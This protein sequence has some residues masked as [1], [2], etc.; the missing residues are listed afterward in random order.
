MACQSADALDGPKDGKMAA[1]MEGT[2]VVELVALMGLHMAAKKAVS[3][4]L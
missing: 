3:L 1:L 4:V 2:M